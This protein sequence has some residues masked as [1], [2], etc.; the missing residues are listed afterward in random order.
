M[1]GKRV[2]KKGEIR[3]KE[4]GKREKKVG[5]S[6]QKSGKGEWVG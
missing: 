6:G 5:K 4:R 1:G 3:A 2:G